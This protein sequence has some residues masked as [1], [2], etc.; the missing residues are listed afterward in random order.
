MDILTH[1]LSG[2][3]LARELADI[4]IDG[5]LVGA[6]GGERAWVPAASGL[7]DED[8]GVQQEIE[9]AR[10]RDEAVRR[11][12]GIKTIDNRLVSG[13]LLAFD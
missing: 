2:A 5:V 10:D 6:G 3:L 9:D 11:I 7:V 1:A 12:Q 13:H 4:R 8:G